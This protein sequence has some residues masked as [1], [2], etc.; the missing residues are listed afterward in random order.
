MKYDIAKNED[1]PLKRTMKASEAKVPEQSREKAKSAAATS[2]DTEE[3]VAMSLTPSRYPGLDER[4][5]NIEKHLAIRYG[6]CSWLIIFTYYERMQFHHHLN[7]FWT[8]SSF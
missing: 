3:G 7:R 2:T 5:V 6:S 1:G 8:V 4:L